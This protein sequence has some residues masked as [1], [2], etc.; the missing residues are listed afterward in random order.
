MLPLLL[1]T[2]KPLPAWLMT[3][4]RYVPVAILSAMLLPALLIAVIG[5]SLLAGLLYFLRGLAAPPPELRLDDLAFGNARTGLQ[6]ENPKMRAGEA[7]WLAF[8]LRGCTA[9]GDRCSAFPA[10]SVLLA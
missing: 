2:L 10:L 9:D 6:A 3:W 4:L 8:K 1:L 5:V 7:V